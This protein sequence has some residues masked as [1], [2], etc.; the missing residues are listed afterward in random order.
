MVRLFLASPYIVHSIFFFVFFNIFIGGFSQTYMGIPSWVKI[1]NLK[2]TGVDPKSIK[3]G[4]YYVLIDEQF[5]T[6]LKHDFY[7]YATKAVSEIGLD[8]TSQIEIEFDPSYQKVQIHYIRIYRG[9]NIID[10]TNSSGL[11][12]LKE[13]TERRNGIIN[14]NNTLYANLSDIRKGDIVE[15]AY[16]VV[17]RNNIFNNYFSYNFGFAYSVP[18]GRICRYLLI[19]KTTQLSIL[20][21]N[22]ELKPEIAEA[23]YITYSWSVINSS[24]IKLEDNTPSWFDPYP[25]VQ[26][27]NCKDWRE[28]KQWYKSLFTIKKYDDTKL[29]I[30]IDSVKKQYHGNIDE[31]ISS[32]VDFTQNH[33]RYLGNTAGIYSHQ[34]H[35]PDYVIENRYGDCKDKSLFLCELLKQI[36][37]KSFPVLLNTE[38]TKSVR[39][40]NPSLRE[41]N[42]CILAIEF[43]DRLYFI[44]PTYSFQRG[45][46]KNKKISNY[47]TG[48]ILNNNENGFI[49]IPSDT[50]SKI[51]ISENFDINS[52][53]KDAIL[54][55]KSTYTG[56][57]A[58]KVR[59]T[60]ANNS[61]VDI[62]ENYR[63]F[64]LKYCAQVNVLDTL[65]AS[66]SESIDEI[67]VS[68]RYLLKKFWSK[69]DSSSTK[70][71]KDFMPYIL[72]ERILYVSDNIRKQPLAISYPVN[73]IQTININKAE[74]WSIESKTIQDD[75]K[76]FHYFYKAT[77]NGSLLSLNYKYLSKIS[78]INPEDY[79][80][81]KSKVDFVNTNIVMSVSANDVNA[82][83]YGFNWLLMLTSLVSIIFSSILCYQLYKRPYVSKFEKKYDQIGGWLVL[84][85]LGI[86]FTPI[87]LSYEVVKLYSDEISINYFYFFFDK[88]SEYYQPLKGYYVIVEN[89]GN[90]FLIVASILII[91]LFFKKK[92]SFRVYY[93]GYRIFNLA[94]LIIDLI[95]I[96]GFVDTPVSAEDKILINTEMASVAKMFVQTCIWVPYILFSD[97]SRHTFVNGHNELN[98]PHK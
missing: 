33:I 67:I 98:I 86:I 23:K 7:H 13:E 76:F 1:E 15:Y 93:S 82:K 11:K 42:H 80:E 38:K 2:E 77:V 21:K 55:V 91:V 81:Y 48:F 25:C 52:E 92:S 51:V 85:G 43:E 59:Y 71:Q 6:V 57:E 60:L 49:E 5:N 20:N 34:P 17:G 64:Y 94:F 45:N 12:L 10:R 30:I 58:D 66:D 50:T 14:E 70:I 8:F 69:N 46:F 22:C 39:T 90:M 83:V 27:S 63:T 61:L 4:Y 9:G 88:S 32:L 78:D 28:V 41:F 36:D 44:D 19:D 24:I 72:N 95:L 47:T 31:Q 40:D 35:Q 89:L 37:I 73:I 87:V 29:K 84:V 56:I 97:R 79:T 68:E 53:S 75:N 18:V 96:Y 3:E 54:T 16:S 62:Q 65:I 74:G 26:I